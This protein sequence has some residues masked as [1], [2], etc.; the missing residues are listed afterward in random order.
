MFTSSTKLFINSFSVLT[1]ANIDDHKLSNIELPGGWGVGGSSTFLN[2]P[3]V[4]HLK[5]FLSW[6]YDINNILLYSKQKWRPLNLISWQA[7]VL[8]KVEEDT[9]PVKFTIAFVLPKRI[10]Q[11]ISSMIYL[12]D[13]KVTHDLGYLAIL[14]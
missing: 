9:S 3:K 14:N 10:R 1:S 8:Y 4:D 11:D 6:N 12:A 7:V 5:V 2:D 13:D